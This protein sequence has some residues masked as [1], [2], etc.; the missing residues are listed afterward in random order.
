M[1][2]DFGVFVLLILSVFF[3]DVPQDFNIKEKVEQILVKLEV[4]KMRARTMDIDDFMRVLQ[5][6]NAEGIHFS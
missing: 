4:E 1:F 2:I 6:F 5:G 3:Q